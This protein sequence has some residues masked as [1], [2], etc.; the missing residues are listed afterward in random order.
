MATARQ[1]A[2]LILPVLLALSASAM[3][4]GAK[5]RTAKFSQGGCGP[6]SLYALSRHLG[7]TA[8][9]QKV[10]ALF[11]GDT[12][13]TSFTEIQA[14]TRGLGLEAQGFEMT[15]EELQ[16]RRPLG[17]LH[18]H[19]SHFVAIVGYDQAGPRI[20]NPQEPGKIHTEVWSYL[21]LSNS[22]DGRVLVVSRQESK[23]RVT[24]NQ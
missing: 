21:K 19:N 5:Q 24:A 20:V 10:A 14:A 13:L 17:I 12:I 16:Q 1:T 3:F 15:M 11:A 2:F 4:W 8:T 9:Y 22:W 7:V 6:T 23:K 18:V